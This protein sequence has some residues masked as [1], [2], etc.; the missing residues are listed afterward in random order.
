MA[1]GKKLMITQLRS[2]IGRIPSHR[3][4]VAALGLKRPGHPVVHDDIPAVRGMVNKVS[5][6]L[7]VEEKEEKEDGTLHDLP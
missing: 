5:Y 7:R 3:K 1:Q 6:L 4:T 2:A